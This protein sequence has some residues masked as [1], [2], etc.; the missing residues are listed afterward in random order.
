M[1]AGD[2]SGTDEQPASQAT[3]IVGIHS[4]DR[5]RPSCLFSSLCK[6]IMWLIVLEALCALVVF[7]FLVWWTMFSGRRELD[8]LNAEQQPG[9][10]QDPS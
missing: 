9:G 10:D 7:V 5:F 8:D 1:G 3:I 2:S 4:A 6:T